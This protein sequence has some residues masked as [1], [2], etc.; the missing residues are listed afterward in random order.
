MDVGHVYRPIGIDAPA[1]FHKSDHKVSDV[2]RTPLSIAMVSC[3]WLTI[4]GTFW[5]LLEKFLTAYPL[6]HATELRM[7]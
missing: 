7:K 3:L 4:C 5:A 2:I 1:T 6:V